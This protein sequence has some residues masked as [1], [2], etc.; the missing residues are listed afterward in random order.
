MISALPFRYDVS[1]A[2][3]QIAANPSAWNRHRDRLDRYGSPHSQV[4][5]I[6]VR[7]NAIENMAADPVAFFQDPHESV[8][9]PVAD[10]IPEV[11]D[12]S[13]RL[14]DA[15]GGKTLGGVL[16]TKI[17]ARGEVKPHI[18]TGWHAGY[19]SKY[20]IQLAGNKEQSFYF[21]DCELRPETGDVYTFDN[22]KLH[23]VANPSQEDRMTLIVCIRRED[24][25][26]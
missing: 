6:W 21:P 23:G 11:K 8:W 13:I 4:S 17:P 20:A 3:E 5:D 10:E 2:V 24:D 12:L 9:Y 19:Y 25:A 15:V 16:I 14:F 22:S 1:K 7:Y 18:D 26:L